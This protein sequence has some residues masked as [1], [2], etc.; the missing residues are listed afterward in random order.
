M[1]TTL[2]HK[3]SK[4]SES[5]KTKLYIVQALIVFVPGL[6][7]A[8]I[9]Y[10]QGT[11]LDLVQLIILAAILLMILGGL[12]LLRQIFDRFFHIATVM[13]KAASGERDQIS[14]FGDISELYEITHSFNRLMADFRNANS[15]LKRRIFE[16]LTI[17]E[18]TEIASRSL[19]IEELLKVLLEKAMTVSDSETGSILLLQSSNSSLR[20]VASQGIS[21]GL[22]VGK[23]LK[24]NDSPFQAVVN[25]KKTKIISN[26]EWLLNEIQS[27]ESDNTFSLL[28]IPIMVRERLV[29]LLNLSV[30]G[31]RDE[32]ETE[33]EQ[34][35]SI[36]IGNIGFALENA[37]LHSRVKK[38][39]QQLKRRAE[40]LTQINKK[41]QQT[42]N[43][44]EKARK[45]VQ[46]ANEELEKRVEE[47]TA[48][49]EKTNVE[50]RKAK[51][52]AEAANIAKSRF[53]ATMS[54]ELLT[55]LN[56]V[57]GFADLLKTGSCGTLNEKQSSY[58]ENI[59]DSG[60]KLIDMVRAI[61]ELSDM[62]VGK[63]KLELS[64]IHVAEE[65]QGVT[66]LMENLAN[67]K[68]ITIHLDLPQALSPIDADRGKFK[69]IIFNLLN[70]AIKFSPDEGVVHVNARHVL[71]ENLPDDGFQR[72]EEK[73]Y[74]QISVSDEGIG[75][76]PEDCQRIFNTFEQ[77][78]A[79]D[80][81]KFAGTGVG[82][83]LSREMV[84]MHK[85]HIWA[86]S[87]G[88]GK[89]TTVKVVLPIEQK[90]S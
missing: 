17:R 53:L 50:L 75:L 38:H 52:E 21:S 56:A 72:N 12:F 81:R 10:R 84:E 34:T 18:L 73:E 83:A 86:E 33:K 49:L 65:I 64:K 15:E 9:Y 82:L 44:R 43:E 27:G 4:S 77:V 85:G 29:A 5:L 31:G 24:I 74:I 14:E 13:K 66:H 47:R 41:L 59:L 6:V 63:K 32:K 2:S 80:T 60:N 45:A 35:I 87:D 48:D 19:D 40:E 68:G 11:P 70:N 7:V 79:S 58:V 23:M 51:Q 54:H 67:K 62:D 90:L 46:K 61:L 30:Q 28:S 89:G 1:E 22:E 39:S 57:I 20:V 55:P 76:K 78:D 16:L 37:M 88:E 42:I 26:S 71:H 36:L 69:K 3:N 25:E 8:Y